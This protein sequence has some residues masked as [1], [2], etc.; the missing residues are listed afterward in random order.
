MSEK[1][2]KRGQR[3]KLILE[4]ELFLESIE[5]IRKSLDNQWLNTDPKNSEERERI[6]F[7]RRMLEVLLIQLSSVMETGKL[8]QTK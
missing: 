8:A 5:E 7:M 1:E 6:Y 4:D 3:A 2:I